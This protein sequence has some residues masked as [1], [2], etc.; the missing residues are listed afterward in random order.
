MQNGETCDTRLLTDDDVTS[1]ITVPKTIENGHYFKARFPWPVLGSAS[2]TFV[3]RVTGNNICCYGEYAVKLYTPLEGEQQRVAKF[4]GR[5]QKCEYVNEAVLDT[6][7][8]RVECDYRCSCGGDVCS[9]VYLFVLSK[10][11]QENPE[12]CDVSFTRGESIAKF[13]LLDASASGVGSLAARRFKF[14]EC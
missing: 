8:G 9:A 14:I 7:S 13:C 6:G 10:S 12:L 11:E 1:C 2:E 4:R 3:A 5:Y